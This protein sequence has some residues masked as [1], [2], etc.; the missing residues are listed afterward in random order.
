MSCMWVF[1]LCYVV[2]VCSSVVELCLFDRVIVMVG[3]LVLLEVI[4]VVYVVMCCVILLMR[5]VDELVIFSF[6]EFV[7]SY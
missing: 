3:V 7:I 5:L 6:F 1:V 2:Y 4:K